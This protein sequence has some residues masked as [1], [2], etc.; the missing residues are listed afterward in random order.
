MI[1]FSRG[2]PR[3]SHSLT[4]PSSTNQI[5]HDGIYIVVNYF[6]VQHFEVIQFRFDTV[7]ETMAQKCRFSHP[8]DLDQVQIIDK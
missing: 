4:R 2:T 8:K 1:S 5:D 3:L 7:D 6:H